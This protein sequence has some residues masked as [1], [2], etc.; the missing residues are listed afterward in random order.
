MGRRKDACDL[1]FAVYRIRST[2]KASARETLST[3]DLPQ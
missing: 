3:R 1:S 2:I